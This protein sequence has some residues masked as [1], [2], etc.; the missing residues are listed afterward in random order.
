M[1]DG[2]DRLG[3]RLKEK[4]KGEEERFFAAK[5]REAIDRLK[6]RDAVDV[7][8]EAK[9]HC[10][11][12]GA[13]PRRPSRCTASRFSS[14]PSTAG[15]GSTRAS[16]RSSRSASTTAGSVASSTARSSTSSAPERPGDV[17]RHHPDHRA[18]RT[19]AGA[20]W[21]RPAHAR[22]DAQAQPPGPR[23]EHRGRRRVP[24]GDLGQRE[25]LHR[26][27]LAGDAAPDDGR[28]PRARR[29]RE[30]RAGAPPRR[31]PRWPHR[32]GPR[33][34]RRAAGCGD[35]G[36]RLGPVS[37]PRAE[38]DLALSGREGLDRRR[39]REPHRVPRVGMDDSRS[40]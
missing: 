21:R 34:R 26:R 27:R 39:R 16:S 3:K 18:R 19:R 23:R 25:A 38:A 33:R 6:V 11:R 17:H 35:A 28:R 40:R 32:A 13:D 8:E 1:E 36:R 4:E 22:P 5:E 37:L 31:P 20:R 15:R 24:H 2:K 10:P 14:V 7:V 12:C 29:T 9:G 30:P